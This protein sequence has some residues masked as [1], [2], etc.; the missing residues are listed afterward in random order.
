M[1][2]TYKTSTLGLPI[3]QDAD[4]P[5]M[6]DFNG[7]FYRL[8]AF[9]SAMVGKVVFSPGTDV[10]AGWVLLNGQTLSNVSTAYPRLLDW[11]INQSGLMVT[12]GWTE[13]K[14]L[15][16][17]AAD[18]LQV[19]DYGGLIPAGYKP[20]DSTFGTQGAKVGATSHTHGLSA[21]AAA[22]GAEGGA[23]RIGRTNL[24]FMS[25]VNASVA[26]SG[27]QQA[28]GFSA[29]LLGNTDSA[30]N[31]PPAITGNWIVYAG[32]AVN[33]ADVDLAV[34][35]PDATQSA[36]LNLKKAVSKTMGNNAPAWATGAD[37]SGNTVDVMDGTQ[38][39]LALTGETDTNFIT[40]GNFAS[41]T[42]GWVGN[43]NASLS[44]GSGY[45]SVTGTGSNPGIYQN[46]QLS[47]TAGRRIFVCARVRATTSGISWFYWQIRAGSWPQLVSSGTPIVGSWMTING[48]YTIPS[49]LTGNLSLSITAAAPA[50]VSFDID[51][52]NGIMCIDMGADASSPLY[53]LSAAQM[54][55]KFSAYFDGTKNISN[56]VITAR[57]AQ[58]ISN[59]NFA[60]SS[61]NLATGFTTSGANPVSCT[62]NTQIF[63]ATA[64]NGRVYYNQ[65]ATVGHR[66]F[67]SAYVKATSNLVQ[68]FVGGSTGAY[69]AHPGDG[70]YHLLYMIS[71]ITST[72]YFYPA[73]DT[74]SSGWDNISVQ[75]FMAIDMGTDASNPL[76]NLTAA[77]MAAQ[78]AAKFPGYFAPQ[79]STL[80]IPGTFASGD[81]FTYKNGVALKNGLPIAA[82]GDYI[83]YKDGQVSVTSD[84]GIA[85]ATQSTYLADVLEMMANMQ[86][87]IVAL[88]GN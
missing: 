68:L 18:T 16:N 77:Q 10:A 88:G 48:I 34:A 69:V 37:D 27:G 22:V 76:Y 28:E 3:W 6:G 66:Y 57:N 20:D 70:Q 78:M 15:Y 62:S 9:V 12:S 31:I 47:L 86:S 79:Q 29:E 36:L 30:V 80:S 45:A 43:G 33:N 72:G 41:G 83:A 74:R 42:T 1:A 13:G 32:I 53:N 71:D 61:S 2:S 51:R 7:A 56:P 46:T 49:G 19:P 38:T 35:I 54:T 50:S 26:F 39:D 5:M 87:A 14:Y 67:V 11:V 64:Q 21:G 60:T 65:S 75:S 58:V 85:P 17:S 55:T 52:T 24:S 25:D 63:I 73:K 59:G 8:D 40:N 44:V 4:A 81:V 82:S 23:L 84:Y